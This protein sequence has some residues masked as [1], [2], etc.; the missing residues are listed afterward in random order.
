MSRT[1][2]AVQHLDAASYRLRISGNVARELVLS[3]DE[4]RKRFGH[5]T[6]TA[7]LQCA[8]NRR[9][10]LQEVKKTAGD[11]WSAGRDRQCVLDGRSATG[12]F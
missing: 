2:G 6:L 10:D 1:H 7:A 11:P 4:L 9:A 5:Q 3:V 8:G 12:R